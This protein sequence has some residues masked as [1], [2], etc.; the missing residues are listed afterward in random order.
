M[1]ILLKMKPAEFLAFMKRGIE[2]YSQRASDFDILII[3]IPKS[4]ASFRTASEISPDFNLHDALKLYATEKGIKLQLIE[5]KSINSYDPCKVMWGLSTSLYAKAT[6]VLWHPEAIQDDTAYIGI[7]YAF[8][9]EKRICIGC[10]QLFDSTGTGIRMV[11]RKINNP[12]LLGKSNPTCEKMM[13][14]L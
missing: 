7:S 10:S 6:G 9:E 14:A 3:Y 5:E 12:I 4:F 1:Q 8:S 2:A 11:L 13:L